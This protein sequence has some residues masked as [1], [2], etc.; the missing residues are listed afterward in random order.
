MLGDR[1]EIAQDAGVYVHGGAPS[2]SDLCRERM[3]KGLGL[4]VKSRCLL[5]G[6][7]E[8]RTTG[9]EDP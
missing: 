5:Y 1:D 7:G 8:H 3:G 4:G 9:E 2:D 6:Q